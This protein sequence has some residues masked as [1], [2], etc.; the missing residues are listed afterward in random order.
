ML[1]TQLKK[2][3]NT[4]DFQIGASGLKQL[5][6]YFTDVFFFRTKVIP[7]S[8]VLVFLLRTFGAKIGKDVR[9]KPGIQVK[10]PWK[11]EIGNNCWLADCYIENLDWVRMGEKCCISQQ[12]MLMTGNHNY[13]KT[14]FNLLTAPIVLEDGV[15]MGA[16]SVVGPGIKLYSHSV[17]SL[18]SVAVSDLAAYTIYQGNPA[19][20]VR[21]REIS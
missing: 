14:T 16:K 3:F 1:K 20:K 4:G 5:L 7:F 2:N 18:S 12:A 9:V 11:L 15:W 21:D 17:L 8:A 13:K 19:V 6:W 10:Y